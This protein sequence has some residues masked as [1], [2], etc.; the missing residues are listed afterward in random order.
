[1]AS[2]NSIT[3]AQAQLLDALARPI[4]AADEARRLLYQTPTLHECLDRATIQESAQLRRELDEAVRR[5]AARVRTLDSAR[6]PAKPIV[7]NRDVLTPRSEFRLRG[8]LVP[9]RLLL[10][11][12]WAILVEL[13]RMGKRKIRSADLC[14]RFGLT[15]REAEV[16]SLLG[17]GLSDRAIATRLGISLRT[18]E[19]HTERVRHKLEAKSRSGAVALL[20]GANSGRQGGTRVFD[21]DRVGMQLRAPLW[22]GNSPHAHPSSVNLL[23]RPNTTALYSSRSSVEAALG[24]A[25]GH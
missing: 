14:S 1:M 2:L 20:A 13:E 23:S 6:A 5:L 22:I 9:P 16:A 4:I 25:R 18:A 19:H 3:P 8:V 12:R 7:L 17:K 24:I 15:A 10:L 21:S 11:D